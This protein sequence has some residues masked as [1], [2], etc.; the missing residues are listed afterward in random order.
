ML[1]LV[2]RFPNIHLTTLICAAQTQ[3]DLIQTKSRHSTSPSSGL[4]TFS[5]LLIY[6]TLLCGYLGCLKRYRIIVIYFI[7]Y[8]LICV[9]VCV[10]FTLFTYVFIIIISHII[11]S[12]I[13]IDLCILNKY[14]T[15]PHAIKRIGKNKLSSPDVVWW[16][17]L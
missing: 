7:M 2:R 14:N 17:C 9:Y 11:I 5:R 6:R 16:H 4:R 8:N 12:S 10:T 3:T 15:V 13:V 1:A